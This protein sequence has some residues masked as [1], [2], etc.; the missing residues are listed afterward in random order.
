[1]IRQGKHQLEGVHDWAASAP[2]GQID[3]F[4]ALMARIK[5]GDAVPLAQFQTPWGQEAL[6]TREGKAAYKKATDAAIQ[7]DPARQQAEALRGAQIQAGID[8]ARLDAEGIRGEMSGRYNASAES[9]KAEAAA[10]KELR[11]FGQKIVDSMVQASSRMDSAGADMQ[12][13]FA[14]FASITSKLA[15]D[16]KALEDK[17]RDRNILAAAQTRAAVGVG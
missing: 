4:N 14:S 17:L 2:Q 15:A 3:Q 7:R 13:A 9:A 10:A 5:K 1:M 12:E 11:E 16:A 8:S 6:Q